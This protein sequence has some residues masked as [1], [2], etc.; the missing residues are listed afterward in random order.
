MTDTLRA[1][2]VDDEAPARRALER[3]LR[4][5][6]D[7]EIAGSVG[8]GLQALDA[9]AGGGIEL[10]LLD[11]EMPV[12][13]GMELATRLYPQV[14]PAVVFV[15]AWP[16][17]AARAF[18]L[19]AADYLLKPVDPLR[20]QQALERARTQLRTRNSDE[21]IAALEAALRTLRAQAQTA[22]IHQVW[23][24]FG[25]GRLRLALEQ[26]EWFAADGDYV[27][28]HTAERGYLMRDSLN[29]LEAALSPSRF[30]RAHRSS[31]VNLDAVTRVTSTANGQLVLTTRSG[32]NVPVGRRVRAK[33]RGMLGG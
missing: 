14:S 5:L 12:L 7:V 18:E 33:V 32:A 2:I 26:I 4:E 25:S 3:M 24:E 13:A 30:V 29:R 6:P 23:V 16:Q 8:D 22:D 27:Q 1:L 21:R 28:A 31:L 9:L 10:V 20:L 15:T 11:I 17:H 19:Q